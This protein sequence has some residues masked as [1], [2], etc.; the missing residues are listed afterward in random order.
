M[1]L[2]RCH[3]RRYGILLF[4][5]LLSGQLSA[6]NNAL[7]VWNTRQI[8]DQPEWRDSLR[9][10][11]LQFRINTLFLYL[12]Y[13][14]SD[15]GDTVVLY[16]RDSLISLL[17][18][19]RSQSLS[20][21][22]LAG[23]PEWALR[24]NH[25]RPLA[26]AREV[27]ALH[28]ETGMPDGIQFDIEPYLLLPFSVPQTKK[29]LISDWI[30]GVWKT[31]KLIREESSL[32]YG[33][34]VPFWMEDTITIEKM[35]MPIGKH[36]S[37]LTDYLA[38]MAYRSKAEG[39]ASV[40]S[41]SEKELEWAQAAHRKI[42]IGIE[43]IRLGGS[44]T[45]YLCEVDPLLFSEKID[46]T[47]GDYEDYRFRR[48]K[49][50]VELVGEKMLLGVSGDDYTVKELTDLRK[51]LI[52]SFDG[53]EITVPA[54]KLAAEV[55][56]SDRLESLTEVSLD[57]GSTALKVVTEELRQSTMYN[58]T[59][60]EFFREYYTLLRFAEQHEEI[61]GIAIHHLKSVRKFLLQ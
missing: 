55:K 58:L 28:K 1:L 2:H 23:E 16:K 27:I 39:S 8:I 19:A 12:S 41:F 37:F 40:I 44:T 14:I 52:E 6:Q 54:Q 3:Y 5:M 26:F 48:K 9:S 25:N 21:H 15:N 45:N 13:D 38:I 53:K 32:I 22:A 43:T 60:D 18:W 42:Y 36:L 20:V 7:W 35:T 24:P 10:V 59:K 50:T 61:E 34:A 31:G 11:T 46:K 17:S 56:K 47:F 49:I 57:D 30:N 51:G 33:I 29:Q 4:F